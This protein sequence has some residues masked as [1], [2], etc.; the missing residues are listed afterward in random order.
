MVVVVV[1]AVE[2]ARRSGSGQEAAESRRRG[3]SSAGAR[4][5]RRA[6][7][8]AEGTLWPIP[9]ARWTFIDPLEQNE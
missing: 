2:W 6:F 1:E 9:G 7:A 3:W 5:E 4:Q 8:R